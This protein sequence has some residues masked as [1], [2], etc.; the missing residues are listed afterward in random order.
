[1][2]FLAEEPQKEAMKSINHPYIC[3]YQ[4]TEFQE[5]IGFKYKFK[6]I[7]YKVISVSELISA[8]AK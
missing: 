2:F 6:R 4:N 8:L 5:V 3:P 1:M 7:K